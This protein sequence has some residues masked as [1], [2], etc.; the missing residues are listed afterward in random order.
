M[1]EVSTPGLD[2][3]ADAAG[4]ADAVDR[5]QMML[6]PRFGQI[7]ALQVHAQAGAEQRLLDVVR[8]QGVAGEQHVDV[9]AANQLAQ[10]L[11]AAGVHDRRA[12]DQQRLAAARV[13][14]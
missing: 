9:A 14:S 12:A 7:A 5:P 6:V 11:A 1:P 4:A 2:G 8:G 3:L 13:G 10:V